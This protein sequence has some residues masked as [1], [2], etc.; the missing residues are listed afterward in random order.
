M[1]PCKPDW[2]RRLEKGP[3]QQKTFTSR[4]MLA[5]EKR[6]KTRAS[7]HTR[8]IWVSGIVAAIAVVMTMSFPHWKSVFIGSIGTNIAAHTEQPPSDQKNKKELVRVENISGDNWRG[9]MMF[10]SDPKSIRVVVTSEPETG[11]RVT[12]MVKR[13]GAIA[14]VNGGLYENPEG[15]GSGFLPIGL[16]VSEAKPFFVDK[17]AKQHIIG[18]TD[19]GNLLIGSY[20]ME[21]LTKMRIK[22][23]V[24]SFPQII[25]GGRPLIS[26]SAMDWGL[27]PR[28]AVGQKA[29]GTVIFIVIDG[30]QQAS[31]G[32]TLKDIQALFL[33]QDVVTAGLLDGGASSEL[34][35][36][37]E[38][39]TT[40]SGQGGEQRIPTGF[41]V[42]D[43]PDRIVVENPWNGKY[44]HS[45]YVSENR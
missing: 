36:N 19:T 37:G 18:F 21:E 42:F 26:G 12:G 11:E 3:F 9:K 28:T 22:E 25:S 1:E 2:Y 23:A 31:I 34:V 30:R 10:V 8:R 39:V 5:V 43:Q 41:L 35:L 32:A 13:T 17:E 33:K 40:P 6:V 20:S 14:G 16:V 45:D 24:T 7:R 15:M 4:S 44:A 27:A 38:L 29:D